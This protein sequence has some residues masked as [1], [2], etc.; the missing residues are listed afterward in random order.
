LRQLTNGLFGVAHKEYPFGTCLTLCT[1]RCVD[2]VVVDRGPYV[3]GRQFDLDKE[4]FAYL[5]NGR[6]D[7]GVIKVVQK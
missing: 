2:V 1:F 3:A 5:T 7:L 4:A 6:L